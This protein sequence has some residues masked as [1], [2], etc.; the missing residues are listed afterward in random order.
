LV[1]EPRLE[2]ASRE[3]LKEVRGLVLECFQASVKQYQEMIVRKHLLHRSLRSITCALELAERGRA[4]NIAQI[5]N[6]ILDGRNISKWGVI[7]HVVHTLRRRGAESNFSLV[8]ADFG[9]S[10]AHA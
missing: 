2:R 5:D 9:I 7:G 6:C 10:A 8:A 1:S 4:V 3:H